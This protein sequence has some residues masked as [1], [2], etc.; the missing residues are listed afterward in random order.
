MGIRLTIRVPSGD[1]VHF[2]TALLADS[3]GAVGSNPAPAS[4]SI[5]PTTPAGPP[6]PVPAELDAAQGPEGSA[7]HRWASR[8]TAQS[9]PADPLPDAGRQEPVKLEKRRHL[10]CNRMR[11]LHCFFPVLEKEKA[12]RQPCCAAESAG[13][14]HRQRPCTVPGPL[15]GSQVPGGFK[16]GGGSPWL[17]PPPPQ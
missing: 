3:L 16:G 7:A 11:Q 14:G 12:P 17:C 2:Q 8:L 15:P 1:L 4:M 13:A 5:L 6:R 9:P 10:F